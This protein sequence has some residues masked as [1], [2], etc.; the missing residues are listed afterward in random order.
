MS[1]RGHSQFQDDHPKWKGGQRLSF[2]QGVEGF[3]I[4]A[5]KSAPRGGFPSAERQ[6]CHTALGRDLLR[7]F[8]WLISANVAEFFGA[9]DQRALAPVAFFLRQRFV[10]K[11]FDLV[12]RQRGGLVGGFGIWTAI[13]LSFCR[14]Q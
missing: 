9:T 12:R 5:I 10:G 13:G 6:F 3:G 1:P 7:F 14:L 4:S 11:R 2:S 8:P